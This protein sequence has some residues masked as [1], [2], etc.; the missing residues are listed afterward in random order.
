[1]RGTKNLKNPLKTFIVESDFD[2]DV[3]FATFIEK[4]STS[5]WILD[6]G[7]PYHMCPHKHQ[8]SMYE[9]I[10]TNLV[11]IGRDAQYNV[12]EVGI[13]KIKT[14]DGFFRNLSMLMILI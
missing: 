13:I 2:S 12:A 1:M 5:Y 8:F 14:H 3:L 7:C 10:N 4:G 9:P 11:H 6:F